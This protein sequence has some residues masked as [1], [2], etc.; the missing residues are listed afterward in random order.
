MTIDQIH[1]AVMGGWLLEGQDCGAGKE[2]C[3][4]AKSTFNFKVE[5]FNM[6]LHQKLNTHVY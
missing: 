2:K 1:A 6:I 3:D 5:A 4:L